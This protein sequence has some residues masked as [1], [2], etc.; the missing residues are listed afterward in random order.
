M[1]VWVIIPLVVAG[2]VTLL[3]MAGMPQRMLHNLTKEE[4]A[5]EIESFLSGTGGAYDWDEFC[6]FTL[7][8]PQLDKIRA[9]CA[10]LDQEF[11]PGLSGGYCSEEGMKV[12]RAYVE[13]L[14]VA[15]G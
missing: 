5:N 13:Q 3:L 10:R 14:R 11:P 1:S 9:R 2:A 15:G 4:V 6:T 8:D 12:L 7:A